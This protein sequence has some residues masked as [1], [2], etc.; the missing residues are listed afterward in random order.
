[1]DLPADAP[2][3]EE[4]R[5]ARERIAPWVHRTALMSNATISRLV[6]TTVLFK[7]EN[8]QKVGAFKARGALNHLLQQPWER[9]E[10]GVV[11]HSSGNHAQAVAWAARLLK[12]PARIVMPENS[13]AVKV[14]AV[15]RYGGEIAFCEPNDE[16]RE[17]AARKIVEETQSH[18]VHPYDNRDIIAGQ[19]SVGLEIVEQLDHPELILAPVGGGGLLSGC[20]LAARY[21]GTDLPVWGAEPELASDA[22]Q[23]LREG[24][25]QPAMPAKTVADGLR[26]GLG[27]LNFGII[28]SA[29]KGIGLCSEKSI[30]RAMRLIWER[31][32]IVVE[33]SA[34]VPLA[35]LLEGTID[36]GG[37]QVI[38]V[39]SGGN[40]DLNRIPEILALDEDG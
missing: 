27:E 34:A 32:K 23:S 29:V 18:F 33:P 1:M 22:Y 6:G 3:G 9:I 10:K 30:V 20:A 38:V 13:A 21:Y 40:V 17:T 4:L 7:C 39:L 31:M 37:R 35:A 2:N 8:F 15:R 25:R 5:E 24:R 14:A 12:V 26:T 28:R 16:A 11:T 19:A 36:R